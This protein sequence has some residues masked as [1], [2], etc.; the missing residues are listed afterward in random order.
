MSGILGGLIGSFATAL[1]SSYESIATVTVGS[2]GAS[3][4]TFSSI[5]GTYKHLQIRAVIKSTNTNNG[6]NWLLT[7]NSD[8][9]NNYAVHQLYADGST[10]GSNGTASYGYAYGNQTTGTSNT[11]IFAVSIMDIFDYSNTNKYKTFRCIGGYDLN[12]SGDINYRSSLWMSTSAITNI[13]IIANGWNLAQYSS[14][15]LYGVKG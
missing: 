5:P 13:N 3:S 4:V 6:S 15:A 10:V 9:A 2:G 11:N 8:T 12:G 14:F 7:A 1:T